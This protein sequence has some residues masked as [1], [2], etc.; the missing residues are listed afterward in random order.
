MW[1]YY[2]ERYGYERAYDFFLRQYMADK[3]NL[4]KGKP[5]MANVIGGK[6]DYLK[7]VKGPDNELY[8]KLKVRFDKLCVLVSPLSSI[9]DVW[10]NEGIEK[11]M[12][13]YSEKNI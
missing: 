2:W 4:V 1:L 10:E 5:D 12:E 11:A 9:L 6:L 13:V 3:G 7:M 8:L